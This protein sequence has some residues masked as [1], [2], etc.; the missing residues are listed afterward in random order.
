V[1]GGHDT[2]RGEQGPSRGEQGPSRGERAPAGA[3]GGVHR[4]ALAPDD[5]VEI[6]V[7]TRI[8]PGGGLARGVRLIVAVVAACL[9]LAVAKPWA[10]LTPPP[11]APGPEGTSV[12]AS[13]GAAPTPVPSPSTEPPERIACFLDPT[14]LAVVDWTDGPT[15]AR[16]WTRLDPAPVAG[17]ADP[18]IATVHVYAEAVWR[19]GFCAPSLDAGARIRVR[20]WRVL[21]ATPARGPAAAVEIAPVP[22]PGGTPT[23]HGILYEPPASIV[24]GAPPSASPDPE[25]AWSVDGGLVPRPAAWSPGAAPAAAAWPAGAYVFHVVIGE[26]GSGRPDEAWFAI[27]LRGPWAGTAAGSPSASP[28]RGPTLATPGASAAPTT[29]P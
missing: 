16:S 13:P 22:V 1:T 11:P 21:P 14:W 3:G 17:P 29:T 18:A 12:A 7:T 8:G 24:P 23:D 9:V 6:P 26:A 20:A 5:P 27:D 2:G 15:T 28:P 10:W 4:R 25:G 19:I